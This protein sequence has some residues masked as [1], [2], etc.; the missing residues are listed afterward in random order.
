MEIDLAALL[1]GNLR[2]L[3]DERPERQSRVH[4][5]VVAVVTSVDDRQQLGRVRVR[6]S[7]G[8]CTESAW[9]RIASPWAGPKNR[10]AYF[11]PEVDDEVLVAFADGN[12]GHPYIL[13]F[14]WS[15]PAPP[16]ETS[17]KAGR[18]VI[19]SARGHTIEL[20]DNKGLIAL[21]TNGGCRVVL[22]DTSG[23]VS[24]ESKGSI[25]IHSTKGDLSLEAKGSVSVKGAE[26]SIKADGMLKLN[27]P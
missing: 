5:V 6:F 3:S 9:A 7:S 27:S 14:L 16:P 17:P 4:G 19:R 10:G 25:A 13:G 2:T 21:Q 24:I 11:V 22:D 18:S 23:K 8:G 20:D 1:E 26:I 15:Q 12:L